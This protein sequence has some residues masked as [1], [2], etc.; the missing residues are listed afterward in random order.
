M[1]WIAKKY[2]VL[3]FLPISVTNSVILGFEQ[4]S[5][6]KVGHPASDMQC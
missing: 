4:Y 5:N 3:S 1:D 2:C 6:L